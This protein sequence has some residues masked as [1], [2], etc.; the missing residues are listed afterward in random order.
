MTSAI[1]FQA[2][3]SIAKPW[4]RTPWTARGAARP[5]TAPA[6]IFAATALGTVTDL[7]IGMVLGHP[8]PLLSLGI[9]GACLVWRWRRPAN[10][11]NAPGGTPAGSA[12]PAGHAVV[13]DRH[14]ATSSAVRG[15]G[16]GR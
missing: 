13:G 4:A 3:L 12:S 15:G 8:M 10:R 14:P 2:W 11:G 1:A 16:D 7:G 5:D 6:W 9:L